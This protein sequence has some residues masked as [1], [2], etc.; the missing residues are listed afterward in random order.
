MEKISNNESAPKTVSFEQIGE[1]IT[2]TLPNGEI[3]S[4][5]G[6]FKGPE[7]TSYEGVDIDGNNTQI[8]FEKSEDLSLF[9]VEIRINGQ[10]IYPEQ[11]EE[12]QIAA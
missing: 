11:A 6:T 10:T 8:Q 12:L 1:N 5:Q 3:I 9:V 2:F 4:V 7:L